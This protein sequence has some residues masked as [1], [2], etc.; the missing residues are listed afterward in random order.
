MIILFF[1]FLFVFARSVEE[2]CMVKS[3]LPKEVTEGD[4]LYEDIMVGGKKIKSNW[5]GV[6]EKELKL[7]QRKCKKKILIK[8]GIPFTPSF[9]LGF[10]GILFLIE[11]FNWL[12]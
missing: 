1:P 10:L 11:K 6:S 3:V 5:E 9:L 12:F 8:Y 4:W 2:S 7:I